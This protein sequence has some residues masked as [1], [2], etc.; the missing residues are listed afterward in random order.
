MIGVLSNNLLALPGSELQIVSRALVSLGLES[1]RVSAFLLSAP[2]FGAR[3]M[4]LQ[5]RI[6][7][8]F[9]IA[10][11]MS[12]QVSIDGFE[13]ISPAVITSIIVIE[14]AVGL[15]AGLCLTIW[16]S[17]MLMAG[18]KIATASGLG[19]AAQVDP[20]SGANTPVVS[21]ILYLFLMVIFVS[22]D[23]HLLALKEIL[24]SFVILPI[25]TPMAPETL[26]VS[27][28][29]AAGSMFLSACIIMLPITMV[30]LMV[31][32]M[33]GIVTRSAPTLNL[34]SFGFPITLMVV[35]VLLFFSVSA[36]AESA[37]SLIENAL[38][39]VDELIL[40][41]RHGS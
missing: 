25:G 15:T 38:F 6:V 20:T 17:A 7:L 24:Q 40:G 23:G 19:F 33:I 29:S 3:W 18:E 34:F 2:L 30:L 41:L 12:N 21:Q 11:A 26:F 16:F 36:F 8:A 14:L 4:P 32:L 35:F 9:G 10:A 22:V 5:V 39:F 13:A 28:I 1:L 27:G 31:N 37:K